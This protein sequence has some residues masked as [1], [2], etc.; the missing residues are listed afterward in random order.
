MSPPNPESPVERGDINAFRRSRFLYALLSSG[1]SKILALAV[2][3]L[4]LPLA[5][6][7]LGT[8]RYA[9]F[10]ALQSFIGWTGI[11]GLG[12]VPSL[13]KF[14]AVAR[15][16]DDA[17]AERSFI[18]S[19][20]LAM[21]VACIVVFASFAVLGLAV[22]PS[23]LVSA[24]GI[25]PAEL[26]AGYFVAAAISVLALFSSLDPAIRAGSQE[27]HRSNIC[28]IA[29][30]AL[31]LAGIV[32]FA[33]HGGPLWSFFIILNLPISVLLIADMALVFFQ[34]PYL[35]HG[36]VNFVETARTISASSNNALLVQTAFTLILYLPTFVV[37]HLSNAYQ[38]AIY[39]SIALELFFALASM[40]L[41]FQPL[42]AAMA[43]A[44]SHNDLPWLVRAYRNSLAIVVGIGVIAILISC[45]AGPWVLRVWLGRGMQ[46][47]H[48][49]GAICGIFFMMLCFV[50]LHFYVLSAIGGLAGIGKVYLFIGLTGLM[51]GS[52]LCLWYGAS[53]MF[54]GLSLSMGLVGWVLPAA[55]KREFAAMYR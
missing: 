26:D 31:V 19:A 36:S 41:I 49:M 54:L 53:G 44:H 27:L 11:F 5:L 23:T 17:A 40:N 1:A 29:A 34:R 42:T 28:A 20:I 37:A 14:I 30:N 7:V 32:Y 43:N 50:Q 25:A 6:H 45:A 35:R 51:L 52:A 46:I 24:H 21:L 15:A 4:A 47:S 16:S 12:L 18:V 48:W 39:G 13:P 38:T 3:L 33:H 55:V 10:L 9:A 2:Q 22:A 8:N